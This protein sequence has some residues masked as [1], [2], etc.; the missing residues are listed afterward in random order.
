MAIKSL[1][2]AIDLKQEVEQRLSK[3][4]TA[5]SATDL[6]YRVIVFNCS[7][8]QVIDCRNKD[9]SSHMGRFA[10]K[11]NADLITKIAFSL[12]HQEE[13]SK[14]YFDCAKAHEDDLF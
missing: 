5:L 10:S 4:V 13:T 12:T 6:L 3:R 2:I 14:E 7:G 9:E 11:I 1:K 8:D